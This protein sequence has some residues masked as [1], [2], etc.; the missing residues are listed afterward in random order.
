MII[1]AC[2]V[3]YKGWYA[4]CSFVLYIN[5][6]LYKRGAVNI[7]G[8]Y[9]KRKSREKGYYIYNIQC[10]FRETNKLSVFLLNRPR[11]VARVHGPAHPRKSQPS[12]LYVYCVCVCVCY[13]TRR[14]TPRGQYIIYI[15]VCDQ[16]KRAREI[17]SSA[18]QRSRHKRQLF[19]IIP[20]G[21]ACS[22]YWPFV[23]FAHV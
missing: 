8:F 17:F 9:C 12:R 7:F 16:I 6:I 11:P 13:S 21:R 5:I 1:I 23:R 14:R 2:Y 4:Q 19:Y 22:V 20:S 15:H 18:G 3:Y 10:C